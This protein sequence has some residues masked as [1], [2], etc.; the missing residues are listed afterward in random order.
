MLRGFLRNFL[1]LLIVETDGVR[2]CAHDHQTSAHE[3]GESEH[4]ES[5][6]H[7]HEGQE[8]R[9]EMRKEGGEKK[10]GG[11]RDVVKNKENSG[12]N[13]RNRKAENWNELEACAAFYMYFTSSLCVTGLPERQEK[14]ISC[15]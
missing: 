5:T 1:S 12:S 10:V 4:D 2:F 9:S 11:E 15:L 7:W 13:Q 6:P 8:Y 14:K 3:Y